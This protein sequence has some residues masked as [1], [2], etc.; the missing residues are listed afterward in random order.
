MGSLIGNI[1][2]WIQAV[3]IFVGMVMVVLVLLVICLPLGGLLIM[4]T[5]EML[6]RM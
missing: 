3:T 6:K 4:D 2:L 5:F 1:L